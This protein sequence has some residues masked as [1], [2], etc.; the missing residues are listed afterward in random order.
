MAALAQR[1]TAHLLAQL[2]PM[3]DSHKFTNFRMYAVW[4]YK[5]KYRKKISET[6]KGNRYHRHRANNKNMAHDNMQRDNTTN[7]V[8]EK[9]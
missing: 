3:H 5:L 7:T 4:F 6:N 2:N 9:S 1:G 8:D